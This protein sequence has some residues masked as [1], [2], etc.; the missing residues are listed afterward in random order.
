MD[1]REKAIEIMQMFLREAMPPHEFISKFF[2]LWHEIRDQQDEA[3][4]RQGDIRQAL[5]QLDE[6]I[7]A[8]TI[9][10]EEYEQSA[11]EQLAK[12]RGASVRPGSST[13][14]IL[15]HV[16]VEA[17]AYEEDPELRDLYQIDEYT[18]RE[19]VREA[20]EDLAATGDE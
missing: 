1:M 13:D 14:R 8:E 16:F 2:D 4:E 9:S 15:S 3:I 11:H 18:L 12:V 5:R 17:D 6:D 10:P 19:V 20:L 7:L